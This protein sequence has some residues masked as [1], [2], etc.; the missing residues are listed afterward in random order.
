[1]ISDY[2]APLSAPR[3]GPRRLRRPL[4]LGAAVALTACLAMDG[5]AQGAGRGG[6]PT[7]VVRAGDTVWAIAAQRYPGDDVRQVVDE[8]LQLNGLPSPIIQP[9]ETLRLPGR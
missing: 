7:V 3:R 5:V 9:G 8:I 6:P 1:M 2:A 4:L